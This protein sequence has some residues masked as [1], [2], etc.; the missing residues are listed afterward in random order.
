MHELGSQIMYLISLAVNPRGRT[1]DRHVI[2]VLL[3][4][5]SFLEQDGCGTEPSL[6]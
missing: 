5:M 1:P 2:A 4:S 6:Q 3:L